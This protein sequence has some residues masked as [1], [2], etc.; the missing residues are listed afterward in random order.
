M[1]PLQK[2]HANPSNKS[3]N[4]YNIQFNKKKNEE[5]K[6]LGHYL[7]N[8]A[9]EVLECVN[10]GKKKLCMLENWFWND[11]E[12]RMTYMYWT[13]IW[14][15]QSLVS[16]SFFLLSYNKRESMMKTTW[17][18]CLY[19]SKLFPNTISNLMNRVWWHAMTI[20]SLLSTHNS[21]HSQ[22]ISS[23]QSV[24]YHYLLT[25]QLHAIGIIQ[26]SSIDFI[27]S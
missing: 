6:N 9:N 4:W 8:E 20:D 11:K 14:L 23:F 5:K 27:V 13:F 18:Q 22:Y 1:F 16:D 2:F 15:Y 19:A 26:F 7:L 25:D 24:N 3:I 21:L 17:S 10:R 12:N